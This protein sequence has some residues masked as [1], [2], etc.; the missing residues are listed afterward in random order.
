[1]WQGNKENEPDLE[2]MSMR[3]LVACEFSG[4]VRRAFRAKGH[5]AW[6]LDLLPCD[7]TSDYHIVGDV[8][9]HLNDGWDMMIAFPPCTYLCGSGIHWNK[10]RP[11]RQKLT[12]EALEFV[13]KLLD[14][15][16]PKIALENPVGV[17]S[18]RIRKPDQIIQPYEFGHDA[19]KRTCLWLQGLPNL[20][21]TEYV[22]P[23][24]VDGRK[25]WGNQTPS[26]QNKLG[27]S[28]DRWKLRSI[29]YEGIAKAMA[30]QW[31]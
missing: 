5:D 7:G 1:L 21:P 25:V 18:S 17:I 13:K 14:A 11:E 22:T 31:G 10:R 6:S 15:P 16:I 30:E 3:V 9:D 12:D 20:V 19:S 29:T 8:L 23:R 27:P 24:I 4:V 28:A 26:G 2:A